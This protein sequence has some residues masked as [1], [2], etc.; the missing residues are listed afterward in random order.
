M[1][2]LEKILKAEVDSD[3]KTKVQERAKQER[4]TERQIIIKAVNLF[5]Q[6]PLKK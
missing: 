3:L 1:S 6:T 4:K 2:R 5:L